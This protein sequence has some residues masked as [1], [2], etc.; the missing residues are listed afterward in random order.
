MPGHGVLDRRGDRLGNNTMFLIKFLLD[1]SSPISLLNGVAHGF[2]D[3]IF[4][5][6][7]WQIRQSTAVQVS[8]SCHFKTFKKAQV[9]TV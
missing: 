4:P 6:L 8:G 5:I 7:F 1:F 3:L 2:A 9:D